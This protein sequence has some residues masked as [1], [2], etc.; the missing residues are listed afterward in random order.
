MLDIVYARI[1]LFSF[2]SEIWM[3]YRMLSVALKDDIKA[4]NKDNK[5]CHLA[6]DKIY[7][8]FYC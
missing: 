8:I 7:N 3:S 6:R 5:N 1:L 2:L 4:V